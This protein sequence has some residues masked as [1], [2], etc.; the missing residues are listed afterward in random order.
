M[1]ALDYALYS[2]A[3]IPSCGKVSGTLPKALQGRPRGREGGAGAVFKI[4]G[5]M[6][7][8]DFSH[9]FCLSPSKNLELKGKKIVIRP[10]T[11]N[12]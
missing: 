4:E 6:C 7:R 11:G 5:L 1:A 12:F 10:K 9:S 3:Q 2:W 8:V